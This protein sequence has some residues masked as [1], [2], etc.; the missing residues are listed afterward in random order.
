[1]CSSEAEAVLLSSMLRDI[2]GGEGSMLWCGGGGG[3]GK[4]FTPEDERCCGKRAKL[5]FRNK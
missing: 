4:R 5:F 3:G 1:M 2:R